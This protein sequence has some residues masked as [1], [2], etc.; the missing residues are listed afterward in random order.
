VRNTA[1][2]I[3]DYSFK[4]KWGV[5]FLK[6]Q[7]S[8]RYEVIFDNESLGSYANAVMAADDVEGGYTYTPSTGIQFDRMGVPRELE[9][10]SRRVVG[11]K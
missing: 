9:K 5:V 10:W 11:N 2:P 6:P 4:T 8:G 3:Y 1:Q 7:S